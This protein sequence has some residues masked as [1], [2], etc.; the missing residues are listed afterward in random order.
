M[1]L[2]P[3]LLL[4]ALLL[5][6]A[7]G[8]GQTHYLF[9]YFKN[10]GEDGL[11]LAHSRDGL[12]WQ[13]LNDDKS[14][15]TPAVGSQKLM[16]DPHILQGPDGVFHM[17]WTT[18]WEGRDIGLAHSQDLVNWSEQ[19][20]LPVMAHE[21]AALNC[22]AP[23][24][25][26]DAAH[27]RYLIFWSTTIAGKFTETAGSAGRGRNHRIYYVT[28]KDF[29]T[30]SPTA[31]LYDGSFNVIDATIVKDGRRYVLVL[32]DE[33]EFPAAKK[34]LRLAIGAK[35]AGPYSAAS[36]PFTPSW[37]EGPTVLRR[38]DE[39]IV[40]FDMYRANRYGAL[41]TRDWKTWQDVTGE[42]QFPA[43]AR[44]G[45]VFAVSAS[46]FRNL[47]IKPSRLG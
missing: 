13:A 45:T 31:L 32:K 11:H 15:L 26:Y 22:W 21:P 34:H 16:R 40:Y 9:A 4:A 17:V 46:V 36:A 2:R 35:A 28:T 39:W 29:K 27:K 14:F 38:N 41:K 5:M 7:S 37:V 18:G 20:A 24:L 30:Y 1:K 25:F 10:N 3:A 43:G 33:T 12:K 44:H 8:F 23:E 47:L 19:Q 6:C 42:L